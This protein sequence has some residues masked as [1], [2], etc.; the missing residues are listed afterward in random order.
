V[1]A[2]LSWREESASVLP[3]V[4]QQLVR[5]RVEPK[6]TIEPLRELDLADLE[7]YLGSPAAIASSFPDLALAIL[8]TDI[9]SAMLAPTRRAC[10]GPGSLRD[11][12]RGGGRRPSWSAAGRSA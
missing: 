6:L 10:Y 11:L 7:A 2:L 3:V 5:I 1:L 12:L 4:A 8:A 9:D